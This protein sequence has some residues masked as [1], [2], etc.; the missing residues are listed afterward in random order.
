METV[1]GRVRDLARRQYDVV[2]VWQLRQ[3]GLGTGAIKAALRGW[4]R[5]H[6]GV[7]APGDLSELGWYMAAA[8][9]GGPGAA[10]SHLSALMLLG[11]RP[12]QPGDIHV[13]VPR[14]GGRR[15]RLGLVIHRRRRVDAG[16]FVG[17]PVT[18][19]TQSLKDAGIEPYELYRALEEADRRG[20]SIHFLNDVV[21]LQR[22][23]R[24][25]TRSDAE[26]RF[27]LLCHDHGIEL[28]LV[29]HRVNGIEADFQWPRARSI[30]EVDG[31]EF[32][33][34]RQQFEDD[35]RREVVHATAG[36][37]VLRVSAAQVQ[38][39]PATIAAALR[40]VL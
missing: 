31:W 3:L 18:S 25:R 14:V 16:T 28:P 38:H 2:G 12:Q 33:K 22:S 36:W 5:V 40:S 34:E 4:R 29:N 11:L 37:R 21:R 35:R 39:S 32:H 8:L 17:I 30:V 27:V 10:I 19:P 13:T 23:I 15:E 7:C 26:A 20:H 9:A 24:G 1:R 6:H